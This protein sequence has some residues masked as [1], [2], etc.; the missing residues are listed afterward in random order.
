[1]CSSFVKASVAA[2]WLFVAPQAH[3]AVTAPRLKEKIFPPYPASLLEKRV[4]G[5]VTVHFEVTAEGAVEKLTLKVP[6]GETALDEAALK[7][8]RS[9]RFEPAKEDGVPLA[10]EI[11]YTF[12]F[13]PPQIQNLAS[14]VVRL[15][16][17]GTRNAAAGVPVTVY[18]RDGKN[19]RHVLTDGGGMAALVALDPGPA[20]VIIK[21]PGYRPFEIVEVLKA[22][23][24]LG[25]RYM[26]ER[27]SYDDFTTV[28]EETRIQETS[29]RILKPR[30]ITKAAGT[31]GDPVRVIQNL[32]GVAR[33]PFGLG[34]LSIRGPA[35]FQ[36]R[37]YFDEMEVPLL[38]H[39]GG[40]RTVYSGDILDR[41]DFLPGGFTGRYGNAV[42][43]IVSSYTRSPRANRYHLIADINTYDSQVLVEGPV[44][45]N[46]SFYAT[47]RRSYIDLILKAL[48][49]NRPGFSFTVAPRY[50]D[51]QTALEWKPSEKDV[52]T[53][54]LLGSDDA[55]LFLLD[56]PADTD[57]SLRGNFRLETSSHRVATHWKKS[58]AQGWRSSSHLGAVRNRV[59][60]DTSNG[61]WFKLTS[62][63]VNLRQEVE[64]DITDELSTQMG[65]VSDTTFFKAGARVAPA[66][67]SRG[68]VQAPNLSG[69][70]IE[71]YETG[72]LATAA[73]FNVWNWSPGKYTF[74]PS[75]RLDWGDYGTPVTLNPRLSAR[76]TLSATDTVKASL[77]LY[78]QRPRAPEVVQNFGNPDVGSRYA[79]H[80]VAGY[81]REIP[82]RF[83]PL[84]LDWQL[85]YRDIHNEIV[86]VAS[87][88]RY[89]NSG[90]GY[91]AGSEVY[92][93]YGAPDMINGWVS[94]TLSRTRLR[95][96]DE[97]SYYPFQNDQTHILTWVGNVPLGNHWEFGLRFR[98]TTGNPYTP[99]NDGVYSANS[100]SYIP[101]RGPLYSRRMPDFHQLDVRIEKRWVQDSWILSAYL[102]I[103]NLY[104]RKNVEAVNYA[105]DYRTS[106]FVNGLP[107][108]PTFG[109]RGEF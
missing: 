13:N 6:S 37:Y 20:R 23:E 18:P 78:H 77:G 86:P 52:R 91:A 103:N 26:I 40:L 56:R 62:W 104:N 105:Y 88:K 22:G 57:P 83:L 45:K 16:E 44:A 36:S 108:L 5:K 94:Y 107:I 81:E 9:F 24:E 34:Q 19:E 85:F 84:N 95:E 82:W 1:M 54:Q 99:V 55:L 47:A 21:A 51:Y 33:A 2:L 80:Y 89:D 61:P 79:I 102:E 65:L 58:L 25:V 8:A 106:T 92:L 72:T 96:R 30:E 53:L 73:L 69:S 43:G 60:I 71:T 39:F 49:K 15:V 98:Y 27:D 67:T 48:L 10:V 66:F 93:K 35:P 101:V 38:F 11:D 28:V 42:G 12:S 50:Y 46:L 4:S 87:S 41:I 97:D 76:R 63:D 14:L 59:L 32:P 17:K 31:Q 7:A 74:S 68:G 3:A 90:S 70:L 29:R 75:H 109:I 100:D 64:H